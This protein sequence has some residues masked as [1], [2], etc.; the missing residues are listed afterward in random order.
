MDIAMQDV[1]TVRLHYNEGTWT[2][3]HINP[4]SV[5]SYLSGIC[6][7]L[8]PFFPEIHANRAS[9]LVK[10][11]LKGALCCYSR[12]TNR[13]SPLTTTQ[14]QSITTDLANSSDHDDMFLSMINTGFPGLLCLGEMAVSD[15]PHL[16]DF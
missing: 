7:N 10:R 11:T 12:P 1:T 14:L 4:K 15:N 9:A 13:K 8:E 2:G 3:G 16:R 5:K 6:N